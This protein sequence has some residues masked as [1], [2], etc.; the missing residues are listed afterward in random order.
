M[1][2]FKLKAPRADAMSRFLGWRKCREI[3]PPSEIAGTS[4]AIAYVS[5]ERGWKGVVNLFIHE[6]DGWTVFHDLSAWARY[7]PIE[8]WLEFAAGGDLVFASADSAQECRESRSLRM[9]SHSV[10]QAATGRRGEPVDSQ[11]PSLA[12]SYA[13]ASRSLG[14]ACPR[15]HHG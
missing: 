15:A 12:S 4:A 5:D 6:S 3:E 14:A 10:S 8:D 13:R 9:A 7:T 2:Y 11:R 1:S